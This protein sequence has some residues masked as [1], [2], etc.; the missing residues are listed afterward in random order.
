MK[1]KFILVM[2]QETALLTRIHEG[3]MKCGTVRPTRSLRKAVEW[4]FDQGMF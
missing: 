1:S 2:G 4:Y 3:L